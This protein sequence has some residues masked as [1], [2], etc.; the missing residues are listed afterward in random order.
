VHVQVARISK[1]LLNDAVRVGPTVPTLNLTFR[2]G[3]ALHKIKHEN[4]V[5]AFPALGC[6]IPSRKALSTTHRASAHKEILKESVEAVGTSI[7]YCLTTDGWRKKFAEWG[8]PLINAV[9]LRGIPDTSGSARNALFLKV[10]HLWAVDMYL[11]YTA[12]YVL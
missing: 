1:S 7:Y 2:S 12:V 3:E 11:Q 10:S 8:V 9:A 4:L 5:N 6:R